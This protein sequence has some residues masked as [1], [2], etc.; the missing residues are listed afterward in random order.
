MLADRNAGAYRKLWSRFGVEYDRFI[1]TTSK[2]HYAAATEVFQRAFDNG[3]VYKGEYSGWYCIPCNLFCPGRLK[4]RPTVTSVNAP[5]SALPRR[6]ISSEL[7]AFQKHL[8]D[9]YEKHPE[10]I[11]PPSRRNEV[12]R[13]V[14]DG[15]K[16]LSISR[17]SVK[18]G[19]PVPVAENHV[20][21][22]W[23]D[24]LVGYLSGIGFGNKQEQDQFR[25][26][27]PAQV[28][29]VGKDIIRFHT[30]YWPAFLLAAGLP[31]PERVP[32]PRLVA[33]GRSQDVQ[34]SRQ[35][36]QSSSVAQS[37]RFGCGPIFSAEGDPLWRRW[38]LFLP[39]HDSKDQQRPRQRLGQPGFPD[40][41][42]DL[43][44]FRKYHSAPLRPNL[45]LPGDRTAG[46]CPGD[47]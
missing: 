35:R 28:Q 2:G 41:G 37:L 38:K 20:I 32:C 40:I 5:P 42:A 47:H 11:N 22:V 33:Q 30:V 10:F 24:A 46:T 39:G 26:Y 1:R 19:I 6:A 44:E 23:F 31:L 3:F 25:K 45:F 36:D 14:S 4:R 27:W 7:S 21:Y 8:L 9:L 29:L 18:W 17:T 16:D 43:Q 34:I 12:I 13:F 15:L